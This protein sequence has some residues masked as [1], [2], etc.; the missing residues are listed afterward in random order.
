MVVELLCT[1]ISVSKISIQSQVSTKQKT[2]A[3]FVEQRATSPSILGSKLLQL[4]YI[5]EKDLLTIGLEDAVV[6]PALSWIEGSTTV[7]VAEFAKFTAV[8]SS[9]GQ[10]SE[11]GERESINL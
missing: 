11:L 4:K 1:F 5:T 8:V 2:S 9:L 7:L 6:A 10:L 3:M